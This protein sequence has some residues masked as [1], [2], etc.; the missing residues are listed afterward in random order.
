MIFSE[1]SL[2]YA[3]ALYNHALQNHCQERV[4]NDLRALNTV[5]EQNTAIKSFMTSPL[6]KA[7]EKEAAMKAALPGKGLAAETETF[8]ALLAQKDRLSLF[9]EVVEA[10]QHISDE[11][12]G[13]VRGVVKSAAVLGPEDRQQIEKIVA[14][15]TGRQVLL[16][17]T[18]DKNLI[19][20]LVA[21][22]GSY[23]FDDSLTS[24]LRRIKEELNRRT[25]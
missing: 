15:A 25:H 2:R 3:K 11:E 5:F 6:V 14:Q 7:S 16:T 8:V 18:E 12:H 4:F 13:V 24:H 9:S 22:V 17:Y 21:E 10:Y 20:G 19:G 23:R 1:I